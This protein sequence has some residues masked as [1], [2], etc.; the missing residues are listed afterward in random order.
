MV[1]R[2]PGL[3][4]VTVVRQVRQTNPDGSWARDGRGNAVYAEESTD[5]P[6]CS[7]QPGTGSETNDDGRVQVTAQT[8]IYAPADWPGGVID[9]VLID[10]VRHSIEGRPQRVHHPRLGHTVVTVREVSG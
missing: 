1:L 6:G 4:T 9:S 3:Q 5:V 2:V 7:V 10:G 8:V